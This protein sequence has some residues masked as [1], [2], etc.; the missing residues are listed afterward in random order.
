V[1]DLVGETGSTSATLPV[2]VAP[3]PASAFEAPRPAGRLATLP[4][5]PRRA[6][7]ATPAQP[8]P[9]VSAPAVAEEA[10]ATPLQVPPAPAASLAAPEA[11]PSV[12]APPAAPFVRSPA[13][14]RENPIA[15]HRPDGS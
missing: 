13:P 5:A 7:L 8:S 3:P 2:V 1:G 14:D 4:A 10:P 11:P 15:T 12:A 9:E 6:T